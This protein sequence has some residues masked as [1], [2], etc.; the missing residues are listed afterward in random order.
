M[1]IACRG[2]KVKVTGQANVVGPT[3]IEGRFLVVAA[4]DDTVILMQFVYFIRDAGGAF[5]KRQ[6][7]KEEEYFRKLV[8]R[9]ILVC[10]K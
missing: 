1:T 7:T 6:A 8:S 10:F 2:L 9:C 4:A 5:G 3:S